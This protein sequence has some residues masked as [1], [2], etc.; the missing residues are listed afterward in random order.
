MNFLNLQTEQ[1]KSELF[2]WYETEMNP[3]WKINPLKAELLS[4][5]PLIVV[6]YYDIIGDYAIKKIRTTAGTRL[7]RSKVF[8]DVNKQVVNPVRT[9]VNTFLFDT[10]DPLFAKVAKTVGYI[11]GLEVR[12]AY[13]AEAL[14]VAS[15][16]SG[17]H[18]LVHQDPVSPAK[19]NIL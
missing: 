17:G 15:Y 19:F 9:S 4:S 8:E 18:Y 10:E 12:E 2:C 11:T 1:V 6:Q 7:T 14:Q 5:R 13:S 16:S 3:M